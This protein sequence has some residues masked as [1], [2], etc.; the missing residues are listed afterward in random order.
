MTSP[1]RRTLVRGAWTLAIALAAVLVVKMFVCDVKHVDSGSM[2]PTIQGSRDNGESVLVLYLDFE[3]QRFDFVVITREGE[4]LPIVKR[5]VGLPKES[6]RIANGDLRIDGKHLPPSAPR[7]PPI[8]VFD[9]RFQSVADTFERPGG[10]QS[11]W[12][13][14]TE[15]WMFD[16]RA[17]AAG[18]VDGLMTFH[19]PL[20][21]GYLDLDGTYVSGEADVNDASFECDV[22]AR[23][24]AG[25][26]VVELVEQGDV[27]RFVLEPKSSGT[28]EASI[29]RR[30]A[31]EPE[32][33]PVE[34]PEEV[35]LKRI[36]PFVPGTW[37]RLRCANVDNGL[38]FEVSG[39][40]E[41]LCAAYDENRFDRADRLK[42]GR[43]FGPRVRF[44]GEGAELVFR[45]IRILRDVHYTARDTHG[46]KTTV[47][48]GPEEYFV[49]G[50]NSSESR[51][52]REWGPV[53]RSSIIGRPIWVVWPL[54]HAR[55]L[56]PTVP[57]ACGR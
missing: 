5:F 7:P 41:V 38:S 16:G 11:L 3:P 54:A 33:T 12:S 14:S 27:F 39:T 57:P 9:D 50:D 6:V 45:G 46:V 19:R 36:V 30:G 51:D 1:S 4:L 28:A 37:I 40:P 32:G 42:E 23:D 52:S 15:G 25:R 43:T 56:V 48:L 35:L 2:A 49:L 55:K 20:T 47:D 26:A 18:S 13:E 10:A 29:V 44:G 24:I 17:L 53:K 34:Y 31:R 21:D 22:L 8:L